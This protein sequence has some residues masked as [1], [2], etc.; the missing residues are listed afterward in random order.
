MRCPA[1]ALLRLTILAPAL[2][3]V[4]SLTP[5]LWGS[6][7]TRELTFEERVRAQ[8]AIDRLYY[9]HQIG[10]SRPFEEAVPRAILE[11]RVRTYLKQSAAL[12]A[13]WKTPI[14]GLALQKELERIASNSRFPE[15]LEEI[16]DALGRDELLIRECLAR[17]ILA[18]RLSRN[19][20]AMDNRVHPAAREEAEHIRKLLLIGAL[21]PAAEHPRRQV[22]E[23]AMVE[24]DGRREHRVP[25]ALA[26]SLNSACAATRLEFGS[27]EFT[28]RRARLPGGVGTIGPVIEERSSFV[29]E[30]PLVEEFDRVEIAIYTIPKVP[31]DEWWA[32]FE[33]EFS[34][35][36]THPVARTLK[37]PAPP[38]AGGRLET[39]QAPSLKCLATLGPTAATFSCVPD[40]TWD[41]GILDD[42]PLG[43]GGHSLVWTGSV[44]IVWGGIGPPTGSL[45]S[46]ARYDPVLDTW[47]PISAIGAPQARDQHTAVW[48]GTSMIV[49][50]GVGAGGVPLVDG[51]RYDPV[52]DTWTPTS[53][54]GAPSGRFFH[55]AVWTGNEM[56]VWGGTSGV[57]TN[58]GGRYDPVSDTWVATP[59]ASAPLPRYF[60]TAVWGNGRMIVWGGWG[61]SN[62]SLNTGGQYDPVT[63][64]WSQTSLAG[65]PEARGQHTAVWTGSDMIVWGGY[66]YLAD[67]NF[68]TGA[69]YDPVSNTWVPISAVGAPEGRNWH[70][71]VWTGSEMIVWGG[72]IS[73][74]EADFPLNSGGRYDALADT[75][76]PVSTVNAPSGRTTSAVWTGNQMI[77][78]G[79]GRTTGPQNTGGRYSPETDSWTPTST[80]NAPSASGYLEAVWTGNVMI[81][82]QG[83]GETQG[84]RY[85]PLTDSWA[86]TSRTNAPSPRGGHTAVW[87]GDLMI[88]WGGAALGPANRLNTGGRYNPITDTWQPTS[89]TDAPAGRSA[90]EAVW[91]G[92]RMII[93][94]GFDGSTSL[95]TGG[96]YDPVADTW[97]ATSMT[98]A[99]DRR[100]DHS[101]VWAGSEIIVW[102]GFKSGSGPLN[103]GSR[104]DPVLDEWHPTTTTGA[105]AARELHT[106][107]WTGDEM[108][109]WGGSPNY[110]NTGG[111]YSPASDSWKSTPTAGAPV[112]RYGH[113]AV[114]TGSEMI[115]WGGGI[116]SGGTNTGGRLSPVTGTWTSTST[117]NAPLFGPGVKH[118]AVWTGS[119][120]I[121]WAST[122]GG[123]YALGLSVDND[124]DGLSECAGDCNDANPNVWSVPREVQ[125]L[126]VTSIYPTQLAWGSQS[127]SAGPETLYQIV[128]GTISMTGGVDLSSGSCF[129]TASETE[130]TDLRPDPSMG[131]GFWYLAEARNSCGVGTYGSSYRDQTIPPC[132]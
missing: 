94:G 32:K 81:V 54:S 35:A 97:L 28:R 117:L 30:V 29:I 106:A 23:L 121:V 39:G 89:T 21:D 116:A 26:T 125:T 43:R 99:P 95:N 25:A 17:P 112:G 118:G 58:T 122:Y 86:P 56:I 73:F 127:S 72:Q 91:T 3:A 63:N 60:H 111:R 88:I 1:S 90:H 46:G 34:E 114:W 120:M 85:D 77:V 37:G 98:G 130:F 64:T 83:G 14:T 105:P 109:V 40:D 93:W 100:Y 124:G 82:W 96:R 67:T 47:T 123:R 20:F 62:V 76:V 24:S 10:V 80:L 27:E 7:R 108:I 18:D 5:L 69:R 45:D 6:G 129:Q 66:D 9:S 110:L 50:G 55:T 119:F 36:L 71:A 128:S 75:W 74:A 52:S 12:E 107:I 87:A 70:A 22:L 126:G 115:I 11:K 16:Y 102:G 51:G 113:T 68:D 132:P 79:G 57:L 101:L 61:S 103:S 59:S 48:T 2:L 78:W 33:G 41:N 44:L 131:T 92:S 65:A 15:R 104:Y 42:E 49:W 4:L 53:T 13:F 8:E 19:F 84:S 38:S 31:W